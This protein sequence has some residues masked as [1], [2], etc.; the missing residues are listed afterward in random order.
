MPKPKRVGCAQERTLH[1]EVISKLEGSV[2]CCVDQLWATADAAA[3]DHEWLEVLVARGRVDVGQVRFALP[4]KNA[5]D[6][7]EC[8]P[9]LEC[10]TVA[11]WLT[12]QTV[13]DAAGD[14]AEFYSAGHSW[15]HCMSMQ[16]H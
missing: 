2:F 9:N 10:I 3:N 11:E 6:P 14:A 7:A 5:F 16:G 4:G 15:S 12:V 13:R 1:L 8:G